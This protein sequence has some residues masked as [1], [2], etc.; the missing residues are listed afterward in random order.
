MLVTLKRITHNA[1]LSQETQAFAADLCIDG[2]KVC[3]VRNEGHGGSHEY[4]DWS[5]AR[6][7]NDYAK[8]LPPHVSDDMMDPHDPTKPFS[9]PQT[10]DSLVDDELEKFL[11]EKDA[12]RLR[13][14]FTKTLASKVCWIDSVKGGVWAVS[15]TGFV[16]ERRE[17]AATTIT[18]REKARGH[19]VL[20]TLP[21]DEAFALWSAAV[22]Q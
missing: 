9:Y 4:S 17:V 7:L 16:G 13:T 19:T 21:F 10:A 22:T 1:R 14:T 12:K 3:E 15:L 5:V 18:A 6:K 8:T 11:K 20:N 2:K